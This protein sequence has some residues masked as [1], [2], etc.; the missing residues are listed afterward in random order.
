[1]RARGDELRVGLAGAIGPRSEGRR[2]TLQL[3]RARAG[4]PAEPK[5]SVDLR[6]ELYVRLQVEQAAQVDPQPGGIG[7][8]RQVA[9]PEF[10]RVQ[11]LHQTAA[12]GEGGIPAEPAAGDAAARRV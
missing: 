8:G 3:V 2:G 6:N 10:E 4:R 12:D 1:M 9:H 7:S 11:A 5:G